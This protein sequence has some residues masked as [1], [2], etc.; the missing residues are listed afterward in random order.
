MES[1]RHVIV[2][3]GNSLNGFSV[4]LNFQ[5]NSLNTGF[6]Q[7]RQKG[8]ISRVEISNVD[9]YTLKRNGSIVNLP[10]QVVENDVV[11]IDIVRTNNAAVSSL[12]C[13]AA[14]HD[15]DDAQKTIFSTDTGTGSYIYVLNHRNQT[16]SVIDTST[17]TVIA[18]I[19]LPSGNDWMAM[20]YRIVNQSI[21]LFGKESTNTPVCKIVAD[22]A[23]P[24]FNQVYS[25]G[26]VLNSKTN[27][28]VGI[29]LATII[30]VAYDYQAD[31]MYFDDAS[32]N[33]GRLDPVSNT[34]SLNN[35]VTAMSSSCL[36][37]NE[38]N[39]TIVSPEGSLIISLRSDIN[40]KEIYRKNPSSLGVTGIFNKKNGLGYVCG[41]NMTL[42]NNDLNTVATLS[43]GT[44]WGDLAIGLDYDL[45]M[46]AHSFDGKNWIINTANST[47]VGS[48]TRGNLGTNETRARGC[49]Y[50]PYSKKFYVQGS[51]EANLDGI[52]RVHV[53]NP[54]LWINDGSNPANLAIMDEG[55]IV[56]G[57][58]YSVS[59]SGVSRYDQMCANCL[60]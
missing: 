5:V 38:S 42:L 48:W 46:L 27:I 22:P 30:S 57:D 49:V 34:A 12:K 19:V 3:R 16:V 47:L 6:F 20:C 10:F 45:L 56:V 7:S 2:S 33:T 51:S 15:Q 31:I 1:V 53:Y 9:S 29:G 54:Q 40:K 32:G 24:N 37:F 25:L 23:S 59:G 8:V 52:N 58:M 14:T 55:F 35:S 11:T 60:I 41:N 17:N 28:L 4:T 13:A 39:N 43:T 18:T 21:Y 44:N 50:S 26:D 36:F